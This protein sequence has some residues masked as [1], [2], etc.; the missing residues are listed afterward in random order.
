MLDRPAI[1][2]DLALSVLRRLARGE[3]NAASFEPAP[4]DH[5]AP[6]EPASAEEIARESG[7]RQVAALPW[8]RKGSGKVEVMLITSRDTGR[9]V[10]PKGWPERGETLWDAA[11][12]E[13]GEEAGLKGRVATSEIGRFHYDKLKASGQLLHCEVAVFPL[14]VQTV[15]SKWPEKGQRKRAWVSPKEAAERVQ[16]PELSKLLKGFSGTARSL[17]A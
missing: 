13:A 10:L 17:A 12:R 16:E 8:R 11:A 14:E 4:G 15:A 1:S 9:W 2:L 7:P 5:L 6:P 3:R